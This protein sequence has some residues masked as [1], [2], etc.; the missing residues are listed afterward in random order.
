[1]TTPYTAYQQRLARSEITFDA[2]QARAVDELERLHGQLIAAG[3]PA[4][5]WKRRLLRVVGRE[6]APVRGLYLWGSVGR[7][8]TFL[9]DLFFSCLPFEDKLRQHFHRFMSAVHDDLKLYR[10]HRDPLELVADR[11][12]R[13]TRV[14]CFDEFAVNDIADAM[15]L[16]NLL[17]ALFAR[18]VTLT[19]TSNIR[20]DALY[21]DGLQRRRFLP[22]IELIK[23]HTTVLHVAG[24][25]DY[26]LRVLERADVYQCPLSPSADSKLAEYFQAM[27]PEPGTT[28]GEVDVL[29]RP[30]PFRRE[31]DGIVW[32]DFANLCDGPRSQL[33]YIEI[34]RC[35]QT[36]ILSAVPALDARQ[37]NQARR[38]IALVDEFY[39]RRV[40][41][42]LSA[43]VP[44]GQLY[45]GRRLAQ[46]FERTR[47]RLEEM[48]SHAYLAAPHRP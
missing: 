39:D 45:S 13:R 24:D 15:I 11:L 17:E 44:L 42:I 46:I 7:G 43:A 34:A 5:S 23:Q 41:L 33:D 4:R 26:R 9:M 21:R 8:K 30:I 48:Q 22:A 47:S 25:T 37:D 12:A 29:G 20:P 40:K 35:Y 1:M 14:I 38:L 2:G 28:E 19:A 6:S 27:A 32:F 16:A 31:A 3:S 36:V 18:G 10:E